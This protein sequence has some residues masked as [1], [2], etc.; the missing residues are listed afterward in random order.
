[1]RR[2]CP[3]LPLRRGQ[4]IIDATP[5]R[6]LLR[7]ALSPPRRK[8]VGPPFYPAVFQSEAAGCPSIR[9]KALSRAHF[10]WAVREH[11]FFRQRRLRTKALEHHAAITSRCERSPDTPFRCA[12]SRINR[13]QAG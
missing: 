1:M 6:V 12:A 10:Y 9:A 5:H 13:L 11:R 4:L 3:N 8:G 7:E 2:I